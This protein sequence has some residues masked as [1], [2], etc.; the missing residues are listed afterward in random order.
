MFSSIF[1][2]TH[3][4]VLDLWIPSG[5]CKVSTRNA[6]F[7]MLILCRMLGPLYTGFGSKKDTQFILIRY[8]SLANLSFRLEKF[9][10]FWFEARCQV[11]SA[12]TAKVPAK[13][14][15]GMS[16]CNTSLYC[17]RRLYTSLVLWFLDPWRAQLITF[18]LSILIS[19]V[20]FAI[21]HLELSWNRWSYASCCPSA[22][23]GLVIIGYVWLV[24]LFASLLALVL[25]VIATYLP[26]ISLDFRL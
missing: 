20:D 23:H 21:V 5:I 6:V 7:F 25:A 18:I 1:S 17:A 16:G 11:V 26:W 10:K 19:Y 22:R 12:A 4:R 3:F 13:A 15:M 14:L 2:K 24:L 9:M 8:N